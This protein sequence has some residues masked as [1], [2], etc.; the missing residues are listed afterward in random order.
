MAG[1]PFLP[2]MKVKISLEQ[3]NKKY[4]IIFSFHTFDENAKNL[5]A[6]TPVREKVLTNKIKIDYNLDKNLLFC[7]YFSFIFG[8][9]KLELFSLSIL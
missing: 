7:M 5:V 3:W 8:K 2:N 1:P 4:F 9:I 6:Q